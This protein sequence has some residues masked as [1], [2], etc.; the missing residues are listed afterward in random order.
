MLKFTEAGRLISNKALSARSSSK[1][2]A[3]GFVVG[4][5]KNNIFLVAR[6]DSYTV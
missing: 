4:H 3:S 6:D 5:E 1:K 2:P